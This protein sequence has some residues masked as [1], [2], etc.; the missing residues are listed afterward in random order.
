MA[1]VALSD[2]KIDIIKYIEFSCVV[3]D[4][5]NIRKLISTG[6]GFFDKLK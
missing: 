1:I 6:A 3:P 4:Y 5:S 2:T